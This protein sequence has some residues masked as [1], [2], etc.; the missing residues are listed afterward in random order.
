MALITSLG[1]IYVI[2]CHEQYVCLRCKTNHISDNCAD[3]TGL[4]LRRKA[5]SQIILHSMFITEMN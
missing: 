5:T 2:V 3:F 1:T 4:K